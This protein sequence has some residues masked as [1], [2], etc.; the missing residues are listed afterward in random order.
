MANNVLTNIL[1]ETLKRTIAHNAQQFD[2]EHNADL[3]YRN[4]MA[5]REARRE[6]DKKKKEA[7]AAKAK[8]ISQIQGT[9]SKFAKIKFRG[10]GAAK[11]RAAREV[12]FQRRR[13][14]WR[15]YARGAWY[16]DA[17]NAVKGVFS[18]NKKGDSSLYDAF[19]Q[20]A[21]H[22]TGKEPEEEFFD[23]PEEFAPRMSYKQPWDS[24]PLGS[25]L[26]KWKFKKW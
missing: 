19:N 22:S 10:S 2:P 8:V 20:L 16:N 15:K 1:G 25:F 5:Y 23:A 6:K 12:G 4:S 3:K 11:K 24:N 17:W 13:H 7:N 21:R 26:D 9:D 14:H 18:S